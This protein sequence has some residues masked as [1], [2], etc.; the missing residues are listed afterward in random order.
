MTRHE[1]PPQTSWMLQIQYE[2]HSDWNDHTSGLSSLEEA[3]QFMAERRAAHPRL[4]Y[5]LV[6]IV[7]TFTVE[8]DPS[9]RS[10]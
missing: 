3:A 6:R 4:R 5:R 1:R 9:R 8:S 7:T 10:S 2:P